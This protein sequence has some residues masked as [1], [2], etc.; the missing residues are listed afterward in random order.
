MSEA[1]GTEET[2]RGPEKLGLGLGLE[3]VIVFDSKH[4]NRDR[5]VRAV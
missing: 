3:E 1:E 2:E 5:T 4:K